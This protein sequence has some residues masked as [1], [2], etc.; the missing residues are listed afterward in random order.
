M[1]DFAFGAIAILILVC[2]IA[3]A[4]VLRKTIPVYGLKALRI[5][6][7]IA[8]MSMLV[9]LDMVAAVQWAKIDLAEPIWFTGWLAQQDWM[10]VAGLGICGVAALAILRTMTHDECKERGW[11]TILALSLALVGLASVV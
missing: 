9:G 5:Q 1:R 10:Q 4:R 6:H 8:S 3:K 2:A 11:L 7:G